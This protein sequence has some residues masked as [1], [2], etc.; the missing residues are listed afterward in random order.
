MSFKFLPPVLSRAAR[1]LPIENRLPALR[2]R[3]AKAGSENLL[4]G[5]LVSR[6]PVERRGMQIITV[7]S[8]ISGRESYNRFGSISSLRREDH[9]QFAPPRRRFVLI[10]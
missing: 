5:G 3:R 6:L 4:L 1:G 9:D 7:H 8:W 2:R 10:G